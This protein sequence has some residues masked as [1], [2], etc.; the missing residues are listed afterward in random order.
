MEAV[1]SSAAETT[2]ASMTS[3]TPYDVEGVV[4]ES[5]AAAAPSASSS[6]VRPTR[7]W[8]ADDGDAVQ[9]ALTCGPRPG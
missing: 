2:S 8:T 1:L 7:R 4:Q 3:A 9:S 6:M 5:T